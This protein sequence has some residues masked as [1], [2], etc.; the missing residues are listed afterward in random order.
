MNSKNKRLKIYH[1]RAITPYRLIENG[2]V[3]IDDG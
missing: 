3:L 2:T 1:G